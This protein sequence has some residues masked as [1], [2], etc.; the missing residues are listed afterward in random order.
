[1]T[2]VVPTLAADETL[3]ACLESLER[4]TWRDFEVIV[5]DNSARNAVEPRDGVRI[6]SND[7]NVGFGVAFNQA[8][9]ASAAPFLAILNDDAAAHPEWLE[10]LLRAVE[11]RPDVGMCASQ[12]RL[13]TDGRLDSAGMLLCLDG[14]SK[15]RGHLEAPGSYP[16]RQEALLPSGSAAFYRREML[17][18]IGLFDESFFLYCEDTDLG[19]RARW[20]AWECLYVP[21]ARVEHR[22]S[23]SAG[24]A[25]PMKAYYVERNRLFLAVKNLPL[26][27]LLLAPFY[28]MSRYFWHL[29]FAIQG[30]GKAAEFQRSGNSAIQLPLILFRAH[31]ALLGRFPSLWKQRRAMKRRFTPKQFRRLIRRFSIGPRQV[32]AL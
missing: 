23:H 31:V 13:A 20:A 25:S 28:S 2:V 26:P 21:D 17:E 14:S 8:F 9:R 32:A 1:V 11:A 4:Q 15:Q 10:S 22:Y 6:I 30:R 5:V 7:R 16:R 3:T 24:K 12:V 18:E 29:V 19:L 27:E